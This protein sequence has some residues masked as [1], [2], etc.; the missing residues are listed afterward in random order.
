MMKLTMY[1][2]VPL[3]LLLLLPCAYCNKETPAGDEL[4]SAGVSRPLQH[5]LA[6]H[7]VH[8]D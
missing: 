8:T 2:P 5:T 4:C 3:L 7:S 1:Q 6:L